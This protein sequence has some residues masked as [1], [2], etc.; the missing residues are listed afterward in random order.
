M[1]N[2]R[3]DVINVPGHGRRPIDGG[4]DFEF[5]G[6]LVQHILGRPDH[7]VRPFIQPDAGF[8]QPALALDV[9]AKIR[10]E[11]PPDSFI[12]GIVRLKIQKFVLSGRLIQITDFH[13]PGN[14]GIA[15]YLPLDAHLVHHEGNPLVKIGVIPAHGSVFALDPFN[16]GREPVISLGIPGFINQGACNGLL[17][18]IRQPFHHRLHQREMLRRP[19]FHIMPAGHGLRMLPQVQMNLPMRGSREGFRRH[20]QNYR[21][22]DGRAA[23]CG[24]YH[25]SFVHAGFGRRGDID[26]HPYRT[27]AS[28]LQIAAVFAADDI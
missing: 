16:H 22:T 20:L 13:V 9:L 27:H 17:P 25:F 26:L 14:H 8:A 11:R 1:V 28:G 19:R 4:N 24:N 3:R 15:G 21:H 7:S 2:Y 18:G 10:Q 12:G 5:R 23:F 6:I